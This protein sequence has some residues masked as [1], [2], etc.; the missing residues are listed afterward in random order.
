MKGRAGSAVQRRAISQA[1]ISAVPAPLARGA[2]YQRLL[3]PEIDFYARDVTPWSVGAAVSWQASRR[4]G[5][6]V[7]AHT[8]SVG[9]RGL[10]GPTGFSANGSRTASSLV[11]GLV[12]R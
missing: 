6:W 8:E 1:S 3:A 5:L 2:V 11:F 7:S 10:R 9:P 4:T 12:M